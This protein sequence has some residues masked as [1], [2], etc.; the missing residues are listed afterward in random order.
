MS[1]V[2]FYPRQ[3]RTVWYLTNLI[4]QEESVQKL[5]VVNVVYNVGGYPE[6]GMD[7]EKSRRLAKVFQAI[8][9]RFDS[10][11]V[12]LD[13]SPW[14]NVVEV[15]SLMVNKFLRI[16]MRSIV[17]TWLSLIMHDILPAT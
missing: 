10:F 2:I 3:L 15:F 14:L 4:S 12:C 11:F 6:G 7:Y 13:E 17:G 16:R 1:Y 5:G 9:I 8:P